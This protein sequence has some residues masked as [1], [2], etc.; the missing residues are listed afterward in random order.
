MINLRETGV[1]PMETEELY[2]TVLVHNFF[3]P[4]RK[5]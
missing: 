3:Q 4:G 1:F 5:G 2:S